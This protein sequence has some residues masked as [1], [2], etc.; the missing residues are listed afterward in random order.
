ML[1][2]LYAPERGVELPVREFA[3]Q[4][5]IPAEREAW[6]AAR[7]AAVAFWERAAGEARISAE[8]RGICAAN[9]Q[10]VRSMR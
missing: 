6:N 8:F 9:A 7:P 2:M 5:P 4:P 10:R 3:P 1:P